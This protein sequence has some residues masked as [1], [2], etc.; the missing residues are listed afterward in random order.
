LKNWLIQIE[1][2]EHPYWKENAYLDII[3]YLLGSENLESALYFFKNYFSS[4]NENSYPKVI[5]WQNIIRF[6]IKTNNFEKATIMFN[7]LTDFPDP[8]FFPTEDEL[9]LQIFISTQNVSNH[10]KFKEYF[11]LNKNN[12][13]F[14]NEVNKQ[15]LASIL[16]FICGKYDYIQFLENFKS[17]IENSHQFD[18]DEIFEL[19]IRESSRLNFLKD[20]KKSQLK[21]KNHYINLL[22]KNF[23]KNDLIDHSI[24]EWM[25][26]LPNLNELHSIIEWNEYLS[27]K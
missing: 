6:Y 17:I 21:L 23:Q 25:F 16:D 19:A 13:I 12:L 2:Y 11:D 15:N 18:L 22:F 14:Q 3:E 5:A 4:D 8:E 9:K 26:E 10:T 27:K 20:L 1:K 7:R 24:Y